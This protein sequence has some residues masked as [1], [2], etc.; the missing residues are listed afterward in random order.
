M[1]EKRRVDLPPLFILRHG[2]TEWNREGRVQGRK[3]SPLTPKGRAQAAAQGR[4][5]GQAV[6]GQSGLRALC[7]PLGRARATATIALRGL[8]LP[9]RLDDRL[10]EVSAGQ[11]EGHLRPALY[12]EFGG[13][14]G[15][16]S[17]FDLFLSAPE[18]ERYEDLEAR[19]RAFLADMRGPVVA[20]THGV[21]S[22]MLRGL[23]LG[24]DRG[25]MA[26]LERGQGC[27]YVLKNGTETCLSEAPA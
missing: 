3:D 23:V 15:I 20:V 7:S 16:S 27:V 2:E 19:C 24:L 26:A 13:P 25:G 22:L 10:Q 11:W 14:G 4:L 8:G 18:G 5:L 6:A 9:L 12:A 1:T 17:E 21:T